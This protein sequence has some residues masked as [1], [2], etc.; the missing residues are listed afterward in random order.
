M[1]KL[2]DLSVSFIMKS[3]IVR[4]VESVSL[5]LDRGERLA[6]IGESG[7][8]KTVLALAI[9]NLLPRTASLEGTIQFMG[10]DLTRE[11]EA[12]SLRGGEIGMC[13]SNA[14]NYFNPLYTVGAQIAETYSL[15]HPGKKKEARDT[16][17]SLMRKLNFSNP[18]TVFRS[19]P[20]QLSGGMNQRAMIA[21]SLVNNPSMVIIDEPT[22]GLDDHNREMVVETIHSMD[23][24]AIFLITHDMALAESVAH[25]IMVM[26]RGIILEKATRAE[27]FS[28]PRHPYSAELVGA[29]L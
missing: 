22:R 13:W 3:E 15:H 5:T 17:F 2:H 14:E 1:L 27:F 8:G 9:L 6:V 18:D 24:I 11:S 28:N 20:H 12:N 16:A 10:K 21:M 29:V 7:C 25:T 19:Y 26:R 23:D 4:A